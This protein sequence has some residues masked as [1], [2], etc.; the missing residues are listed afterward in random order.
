MREDPE[1]RERV[2]ETAT[3]LFARRGF[4]DVTVREI[5]RAA[6]ANVAAVN[7]HFGD[8]LGLYRAV[9]HVAIDAIRGTS[10]SARQAAAGATPEEQ[11]RIYIGVAL[12]RVAAKQRDSWIYQL[13][14][15]EMAD[16]TPALDLIVDQAIRPRIEYLSGLVARI[17]GTTLDDERVLN[18]VASVQSQFLLCLNPVATRVHPSFSLAAAS[19]DDLADHIV[20]FSLGG[21]KALKSRGPV[22]VS[23]RSSG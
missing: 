2:L 18:C 7:Y 12:T 3:R 23:V 21:I 17:L 13:I 22:G 10:E 4:H 16:P 14:G 11:L 9:V 19:L 15:R 20:A 5:C 8:K 6:K 1:T